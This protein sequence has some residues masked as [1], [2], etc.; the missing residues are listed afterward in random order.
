MK[1]PLF[2]TRPVYKFT[3]L[4][5]GLDP[6]EFHVEGD[7][8]VIGRSSDC[9][10]VVRHPYVSKRHVRVMAGLIAVDLA[11]SNGTF[12]EGERVTR[13][14]LLLDKRLR[15][16]KTDADVTVEVEYIG[17]ADGTQQGG[18]QR[19]SNALRAKDREIRALR[20]ELDL[21]QAGEAQTAELE[22]LRAENQKLR[23]E[24]ARYE[25]A[26][27][28]ED[29]VEARLQRLEALIQRAESN[30]IPAAEVDELIDPS[31]TLRRTIPKETFQRSDE[32]PPTRGVANHD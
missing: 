3:V 19:L 32:D 30:D 23:R 29:G 22:A 11:S 2:A 26:A 21:A 9:D 10:V 12:V 7:E 1:R 31:D 24:L 13:P 14:I 25:V 20:A 28:T 8:A 17:E 15:L 16:G 18:D 27:Q 4:Q 6:C 5:P